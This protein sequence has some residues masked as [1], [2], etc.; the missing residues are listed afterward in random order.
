MICLSV[1]DRVNGLEVIEAESEFGELLL[2]RTKYSAEWKALDVET[3]K[4]Y[5]RVGENF[6]AML[7]CYQHQ[8]GY[9]YGC[10]N[11]DIPEDEGLNSGKSFHPKTL[12]IQEFSE[13]TFPFA[14]FRLDVFKRLQDFQMSN[15]KISAIYRTALIGAN[16]LTRLD[17]SHN[18]L[19]ELPSEAFL[20]AVNLIE[21]NLSYNQ[22]AR[23]PS[24]VFIGQSEHVFTT[25]ESPW[26]PTTDFPTEYPSTSDLPTTATHIQPLQNLKIIRLNNNLLT[27]ID[28]NWF[29]YLRSLENVTLNDNQ[30]IE[31]DLFA[32]FH[33]NFGLQKLE[34][35][36]NNLSNIITNA[37]GPKLRIFD[38]SNNPRNFGMQRIDVFARE[39]NISYTKSREC[40]IPPNAVNLHADHNQIKTVFVYDA[41][42]SNLTHLYLNHNEIESADFL[43]GLD[44]MIINLSHNQLTQI[45][46][47]VF[48][49]M[50][51]LLELDIS[52]NKFSTIDFAFIGPPWRLE[53]LNIS[54]NL[55]SGNFKLNVDAVGLVELNIAH[56]NYTSVD[57]SLGKHAPNL[58]HIDL[59]GNYFDCDELTSTILFLTF[60]H[61]RAITP[62]EDASGEDN[63]RGIRCH[64]RKTDGELVNGRLSQDLSKRSYT[65]MKNDVSKSFDDKLVQLENR[66]MQIIKNVTGS[67][68]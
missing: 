56:N 37:F 14:L 29:R 19:K 23:M 51:N 66:L 13:E 30:L 2:L 60:D 43:Q 48:K 57:L 32:A 39:I 3:D 6:N 38:I 16:A 36:N 31:I 58:R 65:A 63:V 52:H 10:D 22:I 8:C 41:S 21:L 28:P 26:Y 67:K 24:D 44:L 18:T 15:F 53:Y 45:G 27:V 46:A 59:N 17:L 64:N 47:N 40:F 35:Q 7:E 4:Y 49:N 50:W 5:G 11:G 42:T 61:I 1:L 68:D 9:R 20:Y 34:L 25:T 12:K 33:F 55:F 62:I 54:N